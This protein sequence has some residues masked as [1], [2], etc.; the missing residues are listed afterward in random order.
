MLKRHL[1]G[2]TVITLVLGL[3]VAGPA[4]AAVNCVGTISGPDLDGTPVK[5]EAI[6]PKNNTTLSS[7]TVTGNYASAPVN[8]KLYSIAKTP[9][10]IRVSANVD[11]ERRSWY[12]VSEAN[13][14]VYSSAYYTTGGASG[15]LVYSMRGT[16]DAAEATRL[17]SCT[18]GI[19]IK[20]G[21]IAG[22]L[23]TDGTDPDTS[24]DPRVSVVSKYS[25][26]PKTLTVTTPLV[27]DTGLPNGTSPT[28][29]H[30]GTCTSIY[31]PNDSAGSW[32][33]NF[34]TKSS[35]VNLNKTYKKTTMVESKTKTDVKDGIK[36]TSVDLKTTVTTLRRSN[37]AVYGTPTKTRV[38]TETSCVPAY[39]NIASS[40]AGTFE[41]DLKEAS[42]E[43]RLHVHHQIESDP[44]S[45]SVKFLPYRS[46]YLIGF[47]DAKINYQSDWYNSSSGRSELFTGASAVELTGDSV[48][49]NFQFK[50]AYQITGTISNPSIVE[51]DRH[52]NTVPTQ[53][54]PRRYVEV[55][56]SGSNTIVVGSAFVTT[57]DLTTGAGTYTIKGLRLGK[58]YNVRFAGKKGTSNVQTEFY[59]V[60]ADG[61]NPDNCHANSGTSCRTVVKVDDS[62][63]AE[64]APGWSMDLDPNDG[65]SVTFETGRSI[66]GKVH[67]TTGKKGGRNDVAVRAISRDGYAT[68]WAYTS[69]SGSYTITGLTPGEY[70]IEVN[71]D[72]Y[73]KYEKS[74]TWYNGKSGGTH[75]SS[76]AKWV[77]VRSGNKSIPRL[78][79]K[80]PPKIPSYY[81]LG[82]RLD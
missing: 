63:Q 74:R 59:S 60:L 44:T 50:R 43:Q 47:S 46:D 81:S 5:V 55:L 48:N 25:F 38:L 6:N 39:A 8:F 24:V 45:Y 67:I 52:D 17:E 34:T 69:S 19:E 30:S 65:A 26:Y 62:D 28:T 75:S 3:V 71:F 4:Q 40:S 80:A 78:N 79:S 29:N 73:K 53:T 22:S 77:D 36:K 70:K 2:A 66:S 35:T 58:S 31:Y 54:A 27:F 23:S 1:L 7:S 21:S 18:D 57:I 42:A 16:T 9:F 32:P 76:G 51:K 33:V 68:R 10:L 15:S 64:L 72:G 56:N 37:N 49:A 12:W 20:F 11:G 13:G 14:K 41:S 61:T 82:E